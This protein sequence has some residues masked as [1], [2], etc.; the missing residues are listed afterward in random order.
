[1][2]GMGEFLCA[3]LKRSVYSALPWDIPWYDASHAIFFTALYGALT[4][5]GVGVLAALLMTF[6]RM[7]SK[8]EGHGLH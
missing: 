7:K 5:I 2:W 4:V 6:K 1:M 8:E 3:E